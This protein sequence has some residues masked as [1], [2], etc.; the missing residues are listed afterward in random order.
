MKKKISEYRER[1]I[2]IIKTEAKRKQN[3]KK[4]K[5]NRESKSYETVSNG[6]THTYLQS[7][8]KVRKK[9][10]LK[11]CIKEIEITDSISSEKHQVGKSTP[12]KKHT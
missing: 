9:K 10:Y 11:L 4:Q 5:Q 8:K 6:L 2:E 1:V 12:P 7:E 3:K